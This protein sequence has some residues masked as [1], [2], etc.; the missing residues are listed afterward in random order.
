LILA[1]VFLLRGLGKWSVGYTDRI[2]IG[3]I[4]KIIIKMKRIQI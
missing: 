2:K 1:L 4:P 3:V